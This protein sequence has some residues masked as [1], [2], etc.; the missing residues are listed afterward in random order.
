MD[1]KWL[2]TRKLQQKESK[3]QIIHEHIKIFANFLPSILQY[4]SFLT[5]RITAQANSMEKPSMHYFNAQTKS[6]SMHICSD[7]YYSFQFATCWLNRD[8]STNVLNF[9]D[10]DLEWTSLSAENSNLKKKKK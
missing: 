10:F 8:I 2:P 5:Q 1:P 4:F 6:F 9:S 7:H 3:V